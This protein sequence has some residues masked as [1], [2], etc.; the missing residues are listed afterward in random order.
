MGKSRVYIIPSLKAYARYFTHNMEEYM[1]KSIVIVLAGILMVSCGVVT[2]DT[3]TMTKAEMPKVVF[4]QEVGDAGAGFEAQVTN[5]LDGNPSSAISVEY[6]ATQMH[7]AFGNEYLV[8]VPSTATVTYIKTVGTGENAVSTKETQSSSF[9]YTLSSA[10]SGSTPARY[11]VTFPGFRYA[12]DVVSN[13]ELTLEYVYYEQNPPT[14][15]DLAVL[16][17]TVPATFSGTMTTHEQVNKHGIQ[18]YNLPSDLRL[19]FPSKYFVEKFV[20]IAI[21]DPGSN[22]FGDPVVLGTAATSGSTNS[23]TAV[24]DVKTVSGTNNVTID[25]LSTSAAVSAHLQGV[26]YKI[27]VISVADDIATARPESEHVEEYDE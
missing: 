10:Q 3:T 18:G 25:I 12:A 4:T 20:Y 6:T 13:V 11:R 17:A 1:K 7:A 26:K 16:L 24:V 27:W 5:I 14:D 9:M 21:A 8:R 22:N 15:E 2:L 19:V 23:S